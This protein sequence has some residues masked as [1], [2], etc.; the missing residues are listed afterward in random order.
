MMIDQYMVT[1]YL[2]VD[3]EEDMGRD[4]EEAVDEAIDVEGVMGYIV[5]HHQVVIHHT[6]DIS[7]TASIGGYLLE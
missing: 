3:V 5:P 6:E 7:D 4:I 1:L 2:A